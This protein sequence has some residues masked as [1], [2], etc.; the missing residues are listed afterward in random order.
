[1]LVGVRGG[2]TRGGRPK[3]PTRR[4]ERR[5]ANYAA[6]VLGVVGL[7]FLDMS[8]QFLLV[9]PTSE[10]KA[11][12]LVGSQRRLAAGVEADQHARQ[13]IAM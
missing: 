9:S 3:A 5:C 2:A 10:V 8:E 4:I 1:M 12:H 11:D 13:M 6:T 7:E